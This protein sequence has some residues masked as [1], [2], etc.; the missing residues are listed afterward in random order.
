MYN[1]FAEDYDRFVNWEN[2]LAYEMP[3]IEK[4]INLLQDRL[5]R[6]LDILDTACGTGMHAIALARTGHRVSAADLFPEMIEKSQQNAHRAGVRVDFKT[7][8]LSEMAG[9]FG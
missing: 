9:S 6:Q 8:G 7:A 1:T 3:F 5:H 4:Q 2:R